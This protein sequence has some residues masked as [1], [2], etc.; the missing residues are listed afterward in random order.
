VLYRD[1]HNIAVTPN[2][3]GGVTVT[4]D[5]PEEVVHA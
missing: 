3:E 2:E 4:I 1:R 5:I